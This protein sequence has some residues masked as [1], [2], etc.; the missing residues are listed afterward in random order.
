M[1]HC[2]LPATPVP[3]A[4]RRAREERKRRK[5]D[6]KL[7]TAAAPYPWQGQKITRGYTFHEQLDPV[8]LVHMNGRVYDPEIGR[9]QSRPTS[10][11]RTRPTCRRSTATPTSVTTRCRSPPPRASSSPDC[12]RRSA[13]CSVP[14]SGPSSV[15]SKP[16]STPRS[17]ALSS[18][19][20]HA[21]S[22]ARPA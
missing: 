14:Y 18:R 10:P 20:R 8:G 9:L 22:E 16:S 2:S 5:F 21:A 19:S 13:M 15:S 17:D 1:P 7:Y 12:S 3:G 4:G 11:S 6:W